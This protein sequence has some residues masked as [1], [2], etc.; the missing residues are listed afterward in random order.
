MGA[1]GMHMNGPAHQGNP[2][3]GGR[4]GDTGWSILKQGLGNSGIGR[5]GEREE[6]RSVGKEEE[7]N[8]IGCPGDC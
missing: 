1:G 3:H 4:P 6:G 5:K 8:G 2:A 7:S